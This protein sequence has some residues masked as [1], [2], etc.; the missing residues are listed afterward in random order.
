MPRPEI[1]V[2]AYCGRTN[3]ILALECKSYLD[4]YGVNFAELCTSDKPDKT[5]KMFRRPALRDLVLQRLAEQLTRKGQCQPEP[6]VVLG[7]IAGKVHGRDAL[8][9]K[10]FFN[11][12]GWVFRGPS[13][14]RSGIRR[15]SSVGYENEVMTVVTKLLLRE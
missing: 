12:Q 13:W 1:D 6:R 11:D 14:I 15:L 2:V 10:S 8:P 3:T 9:I 4:S 5:Y 7:L